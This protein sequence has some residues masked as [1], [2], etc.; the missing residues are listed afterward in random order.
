MREKVALTV[1]A[2][3]WCLEARL[4]LKKEGAFYATKLKTARYYMEHILPEREVLATRINAGK[5]LM[6]AFDADE[7]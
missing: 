6:M 7:F 2:W 5:A 3:I 1:L 4:A